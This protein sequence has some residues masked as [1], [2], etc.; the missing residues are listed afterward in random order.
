MKSYIVIVCYGYWDDGPSDEG[1]GPF[2]SR[3]DADAWG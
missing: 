3:E 1:F 2:D